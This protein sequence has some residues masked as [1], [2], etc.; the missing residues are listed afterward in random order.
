MISGDLPPSSRETFFRLVAALEKKK[1][2]STKTLLN[3][4]FNHF[5]SITSSENVQYKPLLFNSDL[6]ESEINV[7][8]HM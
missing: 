6:A 4:A 1:K 3:S 5:L 7:N 8:K 2:K